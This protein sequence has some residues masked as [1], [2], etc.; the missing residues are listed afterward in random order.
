MTGL[1]K[2]CDGLASILWNSAIYKNRCK[3]KCLLEDVL[4]SYN[5][6]GLIKF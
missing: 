4:L 6:I 5:Y 3:S 2:N 1:K